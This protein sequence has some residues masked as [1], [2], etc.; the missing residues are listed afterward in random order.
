MMNFLILHNPSFYDEVS[1]ISMNHHMSGQQL[2]ISIQFV[3]TGEE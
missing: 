3:E 1:S 2:G